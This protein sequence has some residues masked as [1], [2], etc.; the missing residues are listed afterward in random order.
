MAGTMSINIRVMAPEDYDKV[1]Q[2]WLSITGFG[3]RSV[4]DSREGVARFL[5]RNP[6]T[7]VVA[8]QNGRIVGSIMCGHD[9]RTGCF[10]HVCVARDYRKHGVG[11][12]MVRFAVRALIEEG[13]SKVT[14]IAFKE[15]QVGNVFWKSLGW[16]QREDVNYYDLILNEE[17]ITNFV[18]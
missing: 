8:E 15:N 17:N 6:T 4:D 5:K 9:G 14:L 12:R 10:Y 3:I 7:S 18:K 13:V 2:L 16:T 11:Y 1:Y